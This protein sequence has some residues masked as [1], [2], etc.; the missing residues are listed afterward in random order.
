MILGLIIYDHMI[1]LKLMTITVLAWKGMHQ[2]L[3]NN[4]VIF[5]MYGSLLNKGSKVINRYG[6]LHAIFS[7]SGMEV[8]WACYIHTRSVSILIFQASSSIMSAWG[9]ELYFMMMILSCE[10]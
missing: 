7:L 1:N 5:V 2:F 6:D 9:G 8:G 3:D 4:S 10:Y